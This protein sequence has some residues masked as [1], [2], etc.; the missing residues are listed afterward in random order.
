MAYKTNF[1]EIVGKMV[2]ADYRR[3]VSKNGKPFLMATFTVDVEGNQIKVESMAMQYKA[4]GVTESSAYTGLMTIFDEGFACFKSMKDVNDEKGQEVEIGIVENVEDCTAL[5][6][7]NYNGFK[8]TRFEE[9]SYVKDGQLIKNVRIKTAYPNRVDLEKVEYKPKAEFAVAGVVSQPPVILERDEQEY[10]RMSVVL[11]IYQEAYKDREASVSL[12][13]ITV[14]SRDAQTFDYIQD[15]F[16]KGCVAYLEG[17]LLRIVNRVEIESAMEEQTGRGFGAC[18]L[19]KQQPK[20]KTE[21]DEAFIIEAGYPLE[22]EEYEDMP[23]FNQELW[24][25]AKEEKAAKEQE[26]LEQQDKPK[27]VG[28]GRAEEKGNKGNNSSQRPIL[29]F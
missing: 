10:I 26:M 6:F 20:Y 28:F 7:S 14:E 27:K 18:K 8:Y 24:N 25:L 1:I 9:S 2:R 15:N 22:L 17:R 16:E 23:E 11:P 21:I 3:N 19:N 4:D 29:P 13:E 12:H 5:R